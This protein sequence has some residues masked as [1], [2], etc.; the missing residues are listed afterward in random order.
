MVYI[1]LNMVRA[2]VVDHPREWR[3]CGY[4]ELMSERQRYRLI[5]K[6]ALMG[7]MQTRDWGSWKKSYDQMIET[8]LEKNGLVRDRR[9]TE[10]IAVGTDSFVKNIKEKL[11]YEDGDETGVPEENARG[12]RVRVRID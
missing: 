2:G 9:W 6:K 11:G 7:V 4:N 8:A 5:D 3:F 1:D 12:W 10:S